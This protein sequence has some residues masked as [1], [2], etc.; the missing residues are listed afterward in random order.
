MNSFVRQKH[1]LIWLCLAALLI[2]ATALRLY[3]LDQGL[4]LDEIL[5]DMLNVRQ[6]LG[7]IVTTFE[8]EN[9]HFLYTILAYFSYQVFGVSAWAL[10]LP[11]VMF[12]VASIG[13][14]YLVGR[15]V[16]CVRE[17]LL[18]AALLTV[19][20]Q[21]IWF[22]QNARGYTGLLFWTLISSWLFLRGVDD[23]RLRYWVW[24][25][26]A[27]ALGTYT[28][29]TML[30]VI[31]AQ[32]LLYLVYMWVRR[33]QVWRSRWTGLFVGFGLAGLFTLLLYLPVLPQLFT[34]MGQETSLVQAWKNPLWTLAELASGIQLNFGGG[35]AVVAAL[36]VVGAGLWSY[37]RT[38]PVVLGLLFIPTILCAG[39]VIALGHHLWPRFF[40][41]EIGF[42][43]LV[44]VRGTIIIAQWI[45]GRVFKWKEPIPF[46]V[47]SVCGVALVL[48]A[49]ASVP[50]VYGPKQDYVS[51]SAFIQANLQPG[52]VVTTAGLTVL[53]SQF[54]KTN[55]TVVEDAKELKALSE[56]A[57]RTWFVYTFPNVLAA[58][59]PDILELVRNEFQLIRTF[60]GTVGDG[61]IMVTRFDHV[62]AIQSGR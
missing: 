2:L 44:A 40:F 50:M 35:I 46:A 7:V 1:T 60:D 11:A 29:F 10:R 6:P 14:M 41:F 47:S 59:S 53:P 37:A 51:A 45:A 62:T 16:T 57:S 12:G 28:N 33:A 39:V 36:A 21:H 38:R 8:S 34:G 13:A 54:Y 3:K 31:V 49:A 61:A 9:Q 5:T 4:W 23:S 25:A 22:S 55:W 30:F 24:Y 27:A 15:T 43:A 17:S 20:Y 19:S 58:D 32:F 52:D 42:A 18:A 56:S 48:A 26:V